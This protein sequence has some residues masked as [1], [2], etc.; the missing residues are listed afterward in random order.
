MGISPLLRKIKK[1]LRAAPFPP[2][3]F[4]TLPISPRPAITQGFILYMQ[5]TYELL[6]E[7]LLIHMKGTQTQDVTNG[8]RDCMYEFRMFPRFCFEYFECY[9]ME[10]HVEQV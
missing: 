10:F 1:H 9:Y 5:R 6:V 2:T 3:I 4:S 7:S 8:V